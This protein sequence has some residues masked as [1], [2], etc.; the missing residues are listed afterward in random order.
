MADDIVFPFAGYVCMAGEAIRQ[1]TGV[2]TGY[3]VRHVVAHTAL[4]LSDSEPV[5]VVTT[6]RPH[7]LTDSTNSDSYDF[8]IS[9]YT[10]STWIKI[11]EGRVKPKEGLIQSSPQ[12]D[13]LPR[14]ISVSRWYEIIARV[15]L[16]YGPE[17]RGIAA[18]SSSTT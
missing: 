9:S 4:V 2:E 1:I 8:V 7:K 16:V 5:E 13:I 11:C 17:F 18:L 15:G 12:C 3:S 10:G 14:S 6:L